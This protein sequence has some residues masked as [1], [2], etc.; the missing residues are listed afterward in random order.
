MYQTKQKEAIL[1]ILKNNK[2]KH[3]T[4]E[5]IYD[6]LK[7]NNYHVSLAT[8]Y[9]YLDKLVNDN[10]IRKYNSLNLGKARYQFIAEDCQK[11]N[12]FHLICLKCN[13]LIHL[14]CD[15]L[16]DSIKHLEEEHTFKV[17]KEKVVFYGY[18]NECQEG[19]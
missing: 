14:N 9:R 3:L 18:C 16:S 11:S 5:E 12:H 4:C 6:L 10:I 7:E 13:K 17:V 8:L 1:L 15:L 19:R 2:N